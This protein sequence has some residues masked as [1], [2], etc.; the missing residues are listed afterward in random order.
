MRV[1]TVASVAALAGRWRRRGST[2]TPSN[3]ASRSRSRPACSSSRSRPPTA[4][5]CK[6]VLSTPT[7]RLPRQDLLRHLPVALARHPRHGPNLRPQHRSRPS[8]ITVPRRHRAGVAQLRDP[9]TPVRTSPLPRPPPPRR[10]RRRPRHQRR[11][12]ARRSSPRSS[13]PPT[14]AGR[15]SPTLDGRRLHAGSRRPRLARRGQELCSSRTVSTSRRRN[16]PRARTRPHGAAHRRQPRG[17]VHADLRGGRGSERSDARRV[18][19]RL[20]P[21]QRTLVGPKA[22]AGRARRGRR[23]RRQRQGLPGSQA[24]PLYP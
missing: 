16:A 18:D 5:S 11:L 8:R 7:G 20:C 3:A 12:R 15:R 1:A 4:A 6:R 17:D 24:R 23:H 14:A 13:I 19:A 22:P 9:R 10:D 21:W 2:S